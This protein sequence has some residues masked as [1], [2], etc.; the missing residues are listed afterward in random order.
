MLGNSFCPY[1]H[2]SPQGAGT[3]SHVYLS[4]PTSF[5]DLKQMGVSLP[6]HQKRILCSI[7]GFK[8]WS[9]VALLSLP[10]A[11]VYQISLGIIPMAIASKWMTGTSKANQPELKRLMRQHHLLSFLFPL[12]LALQQPSVRFRALVLDTVL[13]PVFCSPFCSALSNPCS[14]HTGVSDP[15]YITWKRK[16]TYKMGC[17]QWTV[18]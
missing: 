12:A 18:F 3:A 6:G 2:P 14:P 15:Q 7:Q 4:F 10:N 17:G 16:D 11:H 1:P 5:R 13:S 9:V 8:E